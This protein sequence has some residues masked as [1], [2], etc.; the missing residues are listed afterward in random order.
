MAAPLSKKLVLITGASRGI[1]LSISQKFAHAGASLILVSR[2]KSHLDA[3]LST[4]PP[5]PPPPGGVIEHQAVAGDV[6]D[7]E[8]WEE[9]RRGCGKKLDILVNA[10]GITHYSLLMAT[11][12]ETIQEVIRT[13]LTGSLLGCRAVVRGMVRARSGC[14]INIS[15]AL[16]IK[17][18]MGSVAYAAS[19]AG[20]IGLTRSLAAE[21]GSSGVRVNAILPGYIDTDITS[22]MTE[23]ARK[24]ALELTPMKRMGTAEEVA[25]AAMFLALNRFANGSQVVLDGGFSAT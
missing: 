13:N 7:P 15:S 3:A 11:K 12:T 18:G 16:G 5:P 19:K 14:I 2:T 8:F 23:G 20:I 6:G 9:V 22:G 21:V 1:G 24:D 10:A 25:D 17:A 4:L